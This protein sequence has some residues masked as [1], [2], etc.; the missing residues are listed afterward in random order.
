MQEQREFED[1]FL[2]DSIKVLSTMGSNLVRTLQASD[3]FVA[4]IT[5]L[6]S[7]TNQ[8]WPFVVVPDFAVRAEK[9]R[10]LANAV[11]V[12]TYN[13]V[14]PNERMEWENFTAQT[15]ESWVNESIT[16]IEDFD[17]MDWPIVW[18]YT[19]WDVIHD[20]DEFDK[21]NPGVVGVNTSGPWLP[22]WQTHP[23]IGSDPPYNWYVLV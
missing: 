7:V 6:A 8:A 5:S 9:I 1:Q 22:M 10:S 18:D 20:Y 19:L 21:E 17:G 11:Y 4:S 15:G 2:E 3:A 23:T 14:Q 16:A 13:L 12:N